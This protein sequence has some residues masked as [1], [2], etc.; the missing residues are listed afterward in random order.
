[1]MQECANSRGAGQR[2]LKKSCI[3]LIPKARERP[4]NRGIR[5]DR[6]CRFVKLRSLVVYKE[7]REP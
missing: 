1:M 7:I 3:S 2:A 6:F 5:K 4:R